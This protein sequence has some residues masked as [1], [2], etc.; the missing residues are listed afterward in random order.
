MIEIVESIFKGKVENTIIVTHGN[1]MALLLNHYNKKFGFNEWV[2]LSNP[3][4]YRL[5]LNINQVTI[6]RLWDK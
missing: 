6:E 4:V 5:T 3:D 2:N 1:L